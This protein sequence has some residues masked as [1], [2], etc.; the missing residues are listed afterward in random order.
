MAVRAHS[1]APLRARIIG[2]KC[3]H[4]IPLITRHQVAQI[5][6]ARIDVLRRIKISFARSAC[7]LRQQPH[8]PTRAAP[9]NRARI[10]LDSAAMTLNIKS[11]STLYFFAQINHVPIRACIRHP[12]AE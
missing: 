12:G 2:R 6:R 9:R 5:L 8:Q 1:A 7:P 11:A 3:Q 4:K 10:K